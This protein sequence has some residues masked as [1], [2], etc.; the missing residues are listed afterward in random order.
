MKNLV[1][2]ISLLF[3]ANLLQHQNIALADTN[4]SYYAKI[5]NNAYFYKEANDTTPLFQ[6]PNSYF[7]LLTGD[8]GEDFYSAK[9]GNCLGFVKKTE[10]T[11]MDG[12]PEKPYATIFNFRVTSMS[13]LA[14][15]SEA[16]FESEELITVDFLEDDLFF[17]GN[18]QGQ[19]FFSNST[20]IWHYCS[21][22]KNNKNY[23]G[24]LFSYYCDFET[25]IT[26]NKEYFDEITGTLVFTVSPEINSGMSDTV[27]ALIV[28]GIAITLLIICY[29]FIA[30]SKNKNRTKIPR[31]KRDYYELSE[32]DL[33]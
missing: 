23:Y 12:T 13:G 30:P 9:Y 4:L 7:V 5:T 28:L 27:K 24:Y 31:R 25:S 18:L 33:N 22:T 21:Y 19:E 3:L 29:F 8:A 17:Y 1:L 14:L 20:D 26:D 10:V 32:N 2:V 15:M 16:T 11:P 6:V